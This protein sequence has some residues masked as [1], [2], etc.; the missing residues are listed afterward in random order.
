[1]KKLLVKLAKVAD[2]LDFNG[3]KSEADAVDTAIQ[4]IAQRWPHPDDQKLDFFKRRVIDKLENGRIHCETCDAI[5]DWDDRQDRAFCHKCERTKSI[6]GFIED[7]EAN[8]EP[9][10]HELELSRGFGYSPQNSDDF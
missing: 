5:L 10:D 2:I 4:K 7:E 3:L 9:S 1:M 6:A 8:Y